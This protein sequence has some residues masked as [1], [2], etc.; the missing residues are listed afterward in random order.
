MSRYWN[1]IDEICEALSEGKLYKAEVI[2]RKLFSRV[3]HFLEKRDIVGNWYTVTS[4]KKRLD[5]A[6]YDIYRSEVLKFTMLDNPNRNA[7]DGQIKMLFNTILG[8]DEN[9]NSAFE[10]MPAYFMTDTALPAV[11][12]IDNNVFTDSVG[13]RIKFDTVHG[14]KGETHDATLYLE[15]KE[16]RSTDLNRVIPIWEG[17]SFTTNSTIEY[18][19]RCVYVGLSRPRKLLC[20]AMMGETYSG[21]EKVFVN[22]DVVDIR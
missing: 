12:K 2:I 4:I 16:N 3:F 14:V 6:Y 8:L 20:I 5:T 18:A 21:H 15:T 9:G 10:H 17:K 7:V 22:W 19:R 1:F 13:R 11:T